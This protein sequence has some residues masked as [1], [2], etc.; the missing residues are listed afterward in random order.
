M[1]VSPSR[2]VEIGY[3]YSSL[4]FR[5][6]RDDSSDMQSA[7]ANDPY[8]LKSTVSYEQVTQSMQVRIEDIRSETHLLFVCSF[9]LPNM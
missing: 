1:A 2:C 9:D 7:A 4:T 6:W 8:K 5:E 3:S